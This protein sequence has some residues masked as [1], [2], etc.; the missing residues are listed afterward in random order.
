MTDGS[1][2]KS[3]RVTTRTGDDGFTNLLGPDRVPKYSSRPTAYGTLDEASS[4]LGLARSV[5]DID[6]ARQLIY[7]L[8]NAL[9]KAMAE[10]A[11]PT[12]RQGKAPFT[13]TTQDVERLDQISDE[14]KGKVT[15][16]REFIVPGGTT[17]GAS[18]DLARCIVR[19]G[20]RCVARMVH[21]GEV[22][23]R[24]VLEWLNRLSD[25]IFI[26]ARFVEQGQDGSDSEGA[27]S[28]A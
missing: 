9:Y 11:T 6:G 13:M 27:A 18:L 14:F 25:V 22:T 26:L 23:N 28:R 12:S 16:G 10:L 15:I 21:D 1:G 4:A 8:Q 19:R 2:E 17:C 3:A 5:C 20:E 24:H 7:E